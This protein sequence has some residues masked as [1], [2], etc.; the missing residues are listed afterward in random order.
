MKK[1]LAIVLAINFMIFSI[2]VF[3]LNESES[4]DLRDM[5][6]QPKE[7]K[8]AP[9]WTDYVPSKYENPRTDFKKN[10][11]VK[12]IIWGGVLTDL[13]ITSPIGIPMICHGTTKLKNASYAEKKVKF[14]NGLEEAKNIPEAQK[15]EFYKNLLKS[16]KMTKKHID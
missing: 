12:E 3:A 13:I 6:I 15:A 14:F 9:L 7:P 2:P 5:R 8:D 11:A 4:T 1:I 16:C 10:S